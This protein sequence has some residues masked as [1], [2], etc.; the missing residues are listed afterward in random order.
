MPSPGILAPSPGI[1]DGRSARAQK[2]M[3]PAP[4]LEYGMG[5]EKH[6]NTS[7]CVAASDTDRPKLVHP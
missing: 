6:R 1:K 7:R 2:S 5:T 3:Q 4:A